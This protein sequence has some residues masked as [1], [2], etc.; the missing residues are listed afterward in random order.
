MKVLFISPYRDGTG[1]GHA[2]IDTMLAMDAAGI[3][4]VPRPL[5]LNKHNTTLPAKILELEGKS[6]TGADYVIQ[7][8]LPSMMEYSGRFRKCIA[9]YCSETDSFADSGW[10][11]KLN[12]MSVAWVPNRQMVNAAHT[13][14]VEIPFKVIPY[15]CNTTKFEQSYKKVP[16]VGTEG[17][18][19]F[20]TIGDMANRRKNLSALIQA[21]HTEFHPSEPVSLIVKT[22]GQKEETLAFCDQIK[23]GLKLFPDLGYYKKE[24]VISDI[25]TD[26]SISRLHASCDCFVLPSYGEAW[27][28][29]AFEAMAFGKT[30]IVT[31]YGGFTEYITDETGWLV[32]CHE[33]PV[34][35][36]KDTFPDLYTGRESWAAVSIRH[37]RSCMR[38]AYSNQTLRRQKATLG[39]QKAYNYSYQ[40]IGSLIKTELESYEQENR[41][42]S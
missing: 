1:Y 19:K 20:Y 40:L 7:H 27:G 17:T 29:P 13:S 31:N 12:Q 36:M 38:E 23:M 39:I 14:G 21:F 26:D 6:P 42:P 5:K 24:I 25:V 41:S 30:P 22:W 32:D 3:D 28:I 10:Q 15:P 2:G 35:G 11:H 37:L 9:M 34:F 8:T 4:V 18:F 33:V 16:L